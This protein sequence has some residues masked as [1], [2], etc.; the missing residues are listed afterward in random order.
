MTPADK[1]AGV[2]FKR[3]IKD[4]NFELRLEGRSSLSLI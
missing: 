4:N 2:F 1:S 3:A